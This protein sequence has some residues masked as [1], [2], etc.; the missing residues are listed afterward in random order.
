MRSWLRRSAVVCLPLVAL[1]MP[2][3]GHADEVVCPAGMYWDIYAE[4]CLW[5]DVTVY[6]D[7]NP[8]LGPNPVLGPVGPVGVGGV[9]PVGPGGPGG[10]FIGGP[11]RR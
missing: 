5:V 6:I 2:A 11:G 10:P 3:T 9:G 7:P 8:L 4:Q 1:A